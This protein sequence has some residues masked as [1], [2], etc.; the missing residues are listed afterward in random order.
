ML[1]IIRHGRTEWNKIH[2]LQGRT[3]IPLNEE[4]ISQAEEAAEKYKDVHFDIAFCSPLIRARQTADILL[5]GRNIRIEYDD[6]LR[7]M[8]F[9]IY[10]G[11]ENCF[12]IPDCPVNVLF[13]DPANYKG[14]PDGETLEDLFKRTGEFLDEKIEPLLKEKKDILIV[15][16]GA[17]NSSII[18][19]RRN[20]PVAHFWDERIDNCRLIE[21]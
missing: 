11:I 21:I 13:K 18:C 6:R 17:M 12:D 7:E 9:G 15:G 16:H 20:T 1:Y 5:K 4:G 3:D 2:K 19:Q 14:V 8:S 10:E